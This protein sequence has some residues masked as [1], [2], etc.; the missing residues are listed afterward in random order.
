MVLAAREPQLTDFSQKSAHD[1]P[2]SNRQA[3]AYC[4]VKSE[5]GKNPSY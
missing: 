5:K 4:I 3:S 2:Q 1:K